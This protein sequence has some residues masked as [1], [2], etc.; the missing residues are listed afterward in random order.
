MVGFSFINKPLWV[1]D[2]LK[3]NCVRLV[4]F[5]SWSFMACL[6]G[7]VERKSDSVLDVLENDRELLLVTNVYSDILQ[8]FR[9]FMSFTL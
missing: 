6:H 4:N 3:S 9:H 2:G 5:Q 8:N 1:R 7:L